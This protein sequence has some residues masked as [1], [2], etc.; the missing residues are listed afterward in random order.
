MEAKIEIVDKIRKHKKE[1]QSQKKE[2]IF[3]ISSP[4]Q[5]IFPRASQV[6]TCC[7]E[8]GVGC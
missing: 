3:T 2:L 5:N 1:P 7:E 4:T 8:L 6:P